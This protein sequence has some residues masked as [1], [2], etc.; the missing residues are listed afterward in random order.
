MRNRCHL[1]GFALVLAWV[2]LGTAC[3]RDKGKSAPADVQGLPLG[4][5]RVPLVL[6]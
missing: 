2:L 1:A 4:L 5:W 3:V 6:R